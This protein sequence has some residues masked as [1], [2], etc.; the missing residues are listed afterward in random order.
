MRLV[1]A[2]ATRTIRAGQS[3]PK[4]FISNRLVKENNRETTKQTSAKMK[5]LPQGSFL[6]VETLDFSLPAST[7]ESMFRQNEL[8]R[9][10]T[11]M[12]YPPTRTI[13]REFES[14]DRLLQSTAR[15]GPSIVETL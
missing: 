5:Q 4:L 8:D 3:E 10:I 1:E 7:S 13:D 11:I 2:V 15:R 6:R 12:V 9:R 14:Y